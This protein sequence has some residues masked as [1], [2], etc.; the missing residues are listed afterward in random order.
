M[1]DLGRKRTG[2]QKWLAT[3]LAAGGLGIATIVIGSAL[4]RA[5]AA[6]PPEQAAPAPAPA[7]AAPAQADTAS[8]YTTR[9]V[10]FIGRDTIVTRE[11]LG[12]FL[13]LRRGADKVELLINRRII[14]IAC[15]EAGVEVTAAEVEASFAEDLK[16]LGG[17]TS[18]DFVKQ[19]LRR[20]GKNLVEWKEDVIRPKLMLAKLCRSKISV[21]EDDIRTAFDARF[22]EKVEC[23]IIQ[24]I[25]KE[26]DMDMAEVKKLAEAGY[27]KV[28]DNDQEFSDQAKHQQSGPLASTGG[29]IKPIHH[30]LADVN[31]P[32]ADR[33]LN[34]KIE[35]EA[36]RLQPGEVSGLIKIPDGYMVMKCDKRVPADSTVNPAA[37]RDAL[38]KEITEH[39]TLGAIPKIVKELRERAQPKNVFD[40]TPSG[41]HTEFVPGSSRDRVV[42]F[43]YGNVPITR[44][45][46][47][48][49][50]ITRYGAECLELVVNKRIIEE[51]CKARNIVVDAADVEVALTEKL[52]VVGGDRE[53]FKRMLR[54]NHTTMELY[55]EDVVRPQL[56]LAK[57]S[58]D[59]VKIT[60][61]DLKAAYEA[62]YGE[63]IECRLILW[64][65]DE[66]K[67]A[68][69]EYADLRD[70]EEAFAKKASSQASHE[71]AAHEGHMMDGKNIRLIGRH[72][73]GNQELERELFSLKPGEVSRLVETPEGIVVMK[74]DKRV[75]PDGTV[76]LD[77]VRAKL[78]K[79]IADRKTQIQMPLVFAELRKKAEPRLLLKDPSR[80][81][82]L[83]AEV[84]R[85]LKGMTP[86]PKAAEKAPSAN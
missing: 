53:E 50:L 57:L 12:E 48:E 70:S 42:A 8:D 27:A 20:Y 56:Q 79:E 24:W 76:S 73:L 3:A 22:G 7:P 44:Q 64:P 1:D 29:K 47:G 65:R 54:E 35:S 61:E 55:K 26:M 21:T 25:K 63:K 74:C 66:Q 75:P 14:D 16:G 2:R 39:K 41:A 13:V 36:F 78:Q 82:D 37:V 6:A 85:Q 9:P 51:E 68:M 38:V 31:P 77:S 28:R 86:A 32:F 60:D 59:H 40:A 10:A 52:A 45:D 11:E 58:T 34:D 46:L 67:Y 71:L 83:T 81:E 80:P 17:I 23:R 18:N 43:V 5:P 62:Y 84:G 49:Y 15:R 4:Q 69:S 19:V 30:H 33:A 72:T